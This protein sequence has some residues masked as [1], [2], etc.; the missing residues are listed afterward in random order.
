MQ[1]SYHALAPQ[2]GNIVFGPDQHKQA[3]N[4][5]RLVEALRTGKARPIPK[6]RMPTDEDVKKHNLFVALQMGYEANSCAS[7]GELRVRRIGKILLCDA[8][9]ATS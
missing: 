8:C 6:D 4:L 2:M 1:N 3:D 9:K 7:C 5:D